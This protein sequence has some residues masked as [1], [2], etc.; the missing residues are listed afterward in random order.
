MGGSSNVQ[1]FSQMPGFSPQYYA[2]C[3]FCHGIFCVIEVHII[4]GPLYTNRS[5]L[6][7]E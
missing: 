6:R 5:Q 1:V 4:P 7:I 2:D 3:G